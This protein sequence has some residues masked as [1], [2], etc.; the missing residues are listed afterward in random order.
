MNLE[1]TRLHILREKSDLSARAKTGVSLHCH[2]EHSKEMLDFIPHY[3]EQL[4]IIASFW[5]REQ[6]RYREREGR[7]VDFST[8]FWSPPL[9]PED[10]YSFEQA[11]IRELNLDPLVS[12]TDHDSIDATLEVRGLQREVAVLF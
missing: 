4:P 12:L 10:V 2:T 1:K 5:R 3:A 11:Q 8:S 7:D 6:V 9:P